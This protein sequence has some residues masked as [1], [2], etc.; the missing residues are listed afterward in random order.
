MNSAPTKQKENLINASCL[1]I[2]L[3][4]SIFFRQS[5]PS[6]RLCGNNFFIF[7]NIS[8]FVS[9]CSTTFRIG[10]S[11]IFHWKSYWH[12]LTVGHLRVCHLALCGIGNTVYPLA[13]LH[14]ACERF[15][16]ELLSS[17]QKTLTQSV[18]TW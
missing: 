6:E 15:I 18:V 14:C 9:C 8:L 2:A 10:L 1:V 13:W 3:R 17:L 7:G 4:S 16:L 11:Q 12:F 5:T